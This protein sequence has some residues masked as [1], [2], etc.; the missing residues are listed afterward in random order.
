[1][2]T[3]RKRRWRQFELRDVLW[4]VLV[5]AATLAAYSAGW[6]HRDERNEAM[7]K[8]QE[9]SIIAGETV[10]RLQRQQIEQLDRELSRANAKI[11]DL[12]KQLER[13][14]PNQTDPRA[15]KP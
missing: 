14:P 4:L 12:R 10:S 15:T 11:N 8:V 13:S 6:N 5:V 2:E 1:M 9:G 3:T 7:L